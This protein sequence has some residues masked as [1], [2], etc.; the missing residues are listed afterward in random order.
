MPAGYGARCE[1]CYWAELLE[2]R[3]EINSRAFSIPAMA[4]HF[5]RFSQ[6]LKSRVGEH[7]AAI[8]INR[9][10]SFFTEMEREWRGI[11][12]YALLLQRFGAEK[13]RRARLP[14]AWI[15]ETEGIVADAHLRKA[16]S[17][18]RRIDD[19]MASIPS[20]TLAAEALC[21]YREM[22]RAKLATRKTT[23]Q[24]IRLALRPAA[25]LLLAADP[26]GKRLPD[27]VVLAQYL[28]RVPG[29]VAAITGFVSLLNQR[30]NTRLF[31][32]VDAKRAQEKRRKALEAELV[33]MIQ[34]GVVNDHSL[35]E[36]IAAALAYF[37]RLPRR[38]GYSIPAD[39]IVADEHG[40][41]LSII[42]NGQWYWI[43][44]PVYFVN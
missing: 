44:L 13:L 19:I 32:K 28:E 39:Q 1:Q 2:K 29:Q 34:N 7:K 43:P 36:W 27:Q 12:T 37:H 33:A 17:E 9:Y 25:S 20:G 6:W 31:A 35:R 14:M 16:D 22:L 30:Y 42:W 15:S 23:M 21:K 38:I 41:G 5:A 8:T 26:S 18:R 4:Q 40:C 24:S 11:P 3:I 10:L